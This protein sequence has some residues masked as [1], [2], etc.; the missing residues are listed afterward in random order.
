MASKSPYRNEISLFS[1]MRWQSH[2]IKRVGTMAAESLSFSESFCKWIWK[3]C[4]ETI[5]SDYGVST[6]GKHLLASQPKAVIKSN[7]ATSA[8][9][10]V[11]SVTGAKSVYDN[12]VKETIGGSDR[13]VAL[14]LCVCEGSLCEPSARG[15]DGCSICA[16]LLML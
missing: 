14:E 4:R 11:V 3:L 12:L 6:E 9:P 1:I 5:Y 2:K 8:D 16:C 10:G 15:C 13:C 7:S